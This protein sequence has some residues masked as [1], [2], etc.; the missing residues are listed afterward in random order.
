MTYKPGQLLIYKHTNL[1]VTITSKAYEYTFAPKESRFSK[2]IGNFE[3]TDTVHDVL[4]EGKIEQWTIATLTRFTTE[5][6]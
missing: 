6:N 3:F 5:A 4:Y 2:F 1:P